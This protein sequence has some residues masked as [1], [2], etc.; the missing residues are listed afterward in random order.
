M[1]LNATVREKKGYVALLEYKDFI[2]IWAG[3][4]ISRFGDAVDSIA[5]LW[6]V[7]ELTGSTLMMGTVMAVNAA[8]TVLFGMPAGVL[9]DRVNKKKIMILTDYI[10]GFN[11]ALM[12]FLYITGG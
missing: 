11:T 5:F 4:T 2:K 10:R 6:M 8:P 7:Y 3:N 1:E 12:A 9:V